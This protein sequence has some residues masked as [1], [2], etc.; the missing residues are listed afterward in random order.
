MVS[1]ITLTPLDESRLSTLE[2][3]FQDAE[4]RRRLGGMLPL[5]RWYEYVRTDPR[6][7]IWI[8]CE[9]NTPVG[10]VDLET[11]GGHTAW[12]TL[13]VNPELRGRGYGTRIL[14]AM[15]SR[16]EVTCLNRLK[17][18]VERENIASLRILCSL[19]FGVEWAE[20]DE[21]GFAIL[22]H[23]LPERQAA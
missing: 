5:R 10:L 20:P 23:S 1:E 4:I 13:L 2:A 21:E 15:F 19:G 22:T 12:A 9:E 17:A 16:P 18:I 8:A 7:F 3:W 11:Y 6:R 14:R